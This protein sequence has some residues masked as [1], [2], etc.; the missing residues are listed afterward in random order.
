M[1]CGSG[2]S[3]SGII[4]VHTD[5]IQ[6]ILSLACRD[7]T[8]S[9][10]RKAREKVK[11]TGICPICNQSI[12]KKR[13]EAIHKC[14]WDRKSLIEKIV[15][16]QRVVELEEVLAEYDRI[17]RTRS[18]IAIGCHDC[19]MSYHHNDTDIAPSHFSKL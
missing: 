6:K 10:F 19:H 3:S 12:D 16:D 17:H 11:A 13:V 8:N 9:K 15:G 5:D 4:Q 1:T 14:G 18:I 7:H 2:Q